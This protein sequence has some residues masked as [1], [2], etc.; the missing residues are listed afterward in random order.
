MKT[1]LAES[2]KVLGNYGIRITIP[3]VNT[4]VNKDKTE[5]VTYL[6]RV[7]TLDSSDMLG[8]PYSYNTVEG[9]YQELVIELQ[10][11]DVYNSLK[12]ITMECYSG[13]F[14]TNKDKENTF[15]KE[16][17][18]YTKNKDNKSIPKLY[19]YDTSKKHVPQHLLKEVIY[20]A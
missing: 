20:Y 7:Y 3:V 11:G 18:F 12:T 4:V 1:D 9:V 14:A 5:T 17:E 6:E 19:T 16:Y 15:D 13:N 10:N 8:N 2:Q